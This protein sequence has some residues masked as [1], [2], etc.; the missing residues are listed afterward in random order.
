MVSFIRLWLLGKKFRKQISISFLL[1]LFQLWLLRPFKV[2]PSVCVWIFFEHFLLSGLQ[3]APDSFCIFPALVLG[4]PISPVIPGSL[5]EK[6]FRNQY[7]GGKHAHFYCS[8]ISSRRSQLTEQK[9]ICVY[10]Y[11]CKYFFMQK[12]IPMLS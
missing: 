6:Y 8:I 7:L 11:T 1:K 10:P 9:Y 4:P 5:L 2:L 12:T 3:D